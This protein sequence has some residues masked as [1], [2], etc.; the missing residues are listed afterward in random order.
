MYSYG[1]RS[2]ENLSQC[3]PDLKIVLVDLIQLMDVSIIKATRGEDEQMLAYNTI[4]KNGNRLSNAKYGESAHNSTPSFAADLVPWPLDWSAHE[5]FAYMAGML[6][7][8][9]HA[10][11][12]ELTVGLDWNGNGVLVQDDPAEKLKDGPHVELTRWRDM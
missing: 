5:R 8:I 1:R 9:G 12:I 6:R 11:G 3:H 10:R 7:G 2:L 4:D